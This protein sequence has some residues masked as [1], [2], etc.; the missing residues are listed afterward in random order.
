MLPEEWCVK[1]TS[2][3][4]TT[5]NRQMTEAVRISR[6]PPQ[7]LLN[8][9]LE[10]SAKNLPELMLKYSGTTLGEGGRKRKREIEK[11][12]ENQEESIPAPTQM[13]Q[14]G[15]D[16][17]VA[18]EVQ[19]LRHELPQ[20]VQT[21]RQELPQKVTTLR[22]ELPHTNKTL[23]QELPQKVNNDSNPK[24]IQNIA[25]IESTKPPTTKH[26]LCKPTPR[27]YQT[28]RKEELLK[29]CR[30]RRLVVKA[31]QSKSEIIDHLMKNNHQ[32]KCNSSYNL[33]K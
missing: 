13:D 19:Q 27:N 17:S 16:F 22:Q 9:K 4:Q 10:F 25:H 29:I 32:P 8:S 15:E 28:M 26:Q 33:Q 2:T 14:R 12:F 23:R 6:E 1:V 30:H 24:E 3:H 11:E 21:L 7:N 18:P 31:R 5:L 20:E